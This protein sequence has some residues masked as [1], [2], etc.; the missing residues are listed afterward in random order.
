MAAVS[1]FPAPVRTQKLK[2]CLRVDL[3]HRFSRSLDFGHLRPPKCTTFELR[4]LEVSA[5]SNNNAVS[6]SESAPLL[7]RSK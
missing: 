3:G 4:K 5:A 1:R 6:L 7:T 2:P